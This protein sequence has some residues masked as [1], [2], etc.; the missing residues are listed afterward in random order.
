MHHEDNEI[1][2]L[3]IVNTNLQIS[4]RQTKCET[5]ISQRNVL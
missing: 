5:D 1:D 4:L 2:I 3:A